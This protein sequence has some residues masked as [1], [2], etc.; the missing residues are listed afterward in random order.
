MHIETYI[1]TRTFSV[2][3]CVCDCTV[4][5]VPVGCR[6]GQ[7]E[8]CHNS[9]GIAISLRWNCV[10]SSTP[11]Y[12][13]CIPFS[14][15]CLAGRA[16]SGARAARAGGIWEDTFV[17][18]PW[19][20]SSHWCIEAIWSNVSKK[21]AVEDCLL[22]ISFWSL[23]FCSGLPSSTSWLEC[24]WSEL[25]PPQFQTARSWA[26]R[27]RL[28]SG[29]FWQTW[30]TVH[31]AGRLYFTVEIGGIGSTCDISVRESL[32]PAWQWAAVACFSGY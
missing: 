27:I 23:F 29:M 11:C 5:V 18:F 24:L 2:C 32:L 15:C 10:E 12:S 20:H 9:A 1:Y 6:K 16:A 7:M 30:R 21:Q 26:W 19:R 22:F 14:L 3:V 4:Q 31:K 25:W 17:T 13:S 8:R 28:K